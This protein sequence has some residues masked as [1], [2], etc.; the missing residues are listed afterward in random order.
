MKRKVLIIVENAAVPFDPR[1][2]K[3]ALA[4]RE[5]GYGVTVLCPK[6]KGCRKGY[7]FSEGV[8][9]YRHPI[10][11]DGNGLLGYAWEYTWALFWE[12]LYSWWI[13]FRRGFRV[14]QACNPPDNI[15]LVA[16]Q[17]KL[18]GIKFIF[19][20]HECGSGIVYR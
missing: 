17:F 18:F 13:Y 16:L 9:I 5:A 12:V 10:P 7:E 3:E 15:F 8:H 6:Q 4:L 2:W 19:D 20:H 14:I 1:V 11:K